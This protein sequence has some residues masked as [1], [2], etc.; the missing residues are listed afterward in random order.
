[1]SAARTVVLVALGSIGDLLPFLAV[2]KA[3]RRRGREVVV[4]T[5]DEYEGLVRMLGFEFCAIWD[6][7]RSQGAFRDVTTS[8][9]PE[10]WAR[11]WH[12]FFVPAARPTFDAVERL[13]QGRRCT[14]VAAWSAFGA[15]LACERLGLPLCEVYLSPHAL[16]RGNEGGAVDQGSFACAV[17]DL[18]R[19]LDLPVSGSDIACRRVAFFPEWFGPPQPF[20]PEGVVT[21]GFPLLDDALV[22]F[23]LA[24]LRRFLDAGRPPVVFT[25]GSFMDQADRFFH[26]ALEGCAAL[27]MRAVFLTPHRRQ[28]PESLPDWALHLDYVPLHRILPRAAALVHHGGIG[29]CAQALRAGVPQGIVPIFFDQSDNAERIERLGLGFGLD[30]HGVDARAMA[31]LLARCL[32][33]DPAAADEVRARFGEG[34]ASDAICERIEVLDLQDAD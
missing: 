31:D 18:R 6:G 16:H 1:M 26:A 22:P 5:H 21:T 17:D 19:T 32:A 10:I 25:P 33:V 30:R 8:N 4:A 24:E 11:V 27:G 2:G 3:M 13:A 23:S 34:D 7:R 29:T 15:R 9:A 28:V 14:V 20:W 12:E